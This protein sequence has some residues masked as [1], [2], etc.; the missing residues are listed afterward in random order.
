VIERAGRRAVSCL[1]VTPAL[2]ARQR[3]TID[4]AARVHRQRV[5]A[6]D[7][8]EVGTQG[9]GFLV[10]F[11]TPDAAVACAMSLQRQMAETRE[12]GSFVP[13]LRVGVHAGEA[14]ADDN[15]LVGRVINLAARVTD[16]AEPGEILVTEPVADHLSPG[17][18]LVDRG[19]RPLK[20]FAQPRHL[21]AVAWHPTKETIVLTTE[22]ED[23]QS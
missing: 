11:A 14:V 16:A 3:K 2:G 12:R 17:I 18:A 22:M 7:G 8:S 19:L 4:L 15:D 10:R 13:E 20:G 5:D 21:L 9:D 1:D 6:H 23:E